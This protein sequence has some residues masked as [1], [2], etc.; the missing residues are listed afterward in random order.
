M[1]IACF[2]DKSKGVKEVSLTMHC[3][4]HV[5]H[6]VL[7]CVQIQSAALIHPTVPPGYLMENQL[8]V[9]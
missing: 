7:L 9:G 2:K 3:E 4:M 5:S 1:T 8:S 6:H